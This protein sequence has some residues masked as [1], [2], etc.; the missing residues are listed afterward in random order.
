MADETDPI[1]F[2]RMI[3]DPYF[4]KPLYTRLRELIRLIGTWPKDID[5]RID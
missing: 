1:D 2:V 4:F 3:K 5:T